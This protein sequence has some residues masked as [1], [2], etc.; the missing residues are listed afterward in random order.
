M[1]D[2][3]L[4]YPGFSFEIT[5]QHQGQMAR[6]GRIT[7]PHGVVETPNFIFCGTRATVKALNPQQLTDVGAQII[8]SNTYHLMIQPGSELIQKLGGLHKFCGW[9]GPMLT[10]SGG[11]QIFA[12]QHGSV[13]ED[14]SGKKLENTK[15]SLLKITEDGAYF[16]SYKD[17]RKLFLSPEISIQI[18]RQLGADLIVQ[19]D[20]CTAYQDSKDY[21]ARGVERS[22]RWGDRSLAEFATTHYEADLGRQAMYGVIQGAHFEDLRHISTDYV[23]SRPFFG[24]AIGGSMGKGPADLDMVTQWC[25]ARAN[26]ARPRHLLGYGHMRDVFG[27]VRRGVDTLDCVH[28]TRLARHGC[29]IIKGVAGER[30][31]LNNG[32]YRDDPTP[33][34]P[35]C[36]CYAE[37]FS[38]AY[39]HHLLKSDELLAMQLLTLHNARTMMRLVEDVR[40]AV[41]NNTLDDCEIAWL[42]A[43]VTV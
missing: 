11:Y 23:N 7:T 43:I 21:S 39:I 10:D 15:K 32:K 41:K 28:P 22:M 2:Q 29:A 5:H 38:K 8:L 42:G 40:E 36:T 30:I 13:S 33:L 26:P 6:C 1:F 14:T 34:D 12:M 25:T 3:K 37:Q 4:D 9:H 17:G 27:A 31:N 16:R 20:E 18:Q 19:L 35:T 24:V